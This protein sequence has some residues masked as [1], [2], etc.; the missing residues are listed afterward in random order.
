VVLGVV[1]PG[2]GEFGFEAGGVAPGVVL[3]GAVLFPGLLGVVSGVVVLGVV[4][5]VGVVVVFG[6][7]PGVV[8]PGF[9]LV[10]A[11]VG[12]TVLDGGETVPGVAWF[13]VA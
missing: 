6:V 5:G 13:G 9:W 10:G 4:C 11:G 2:V 12:A 8:A 7:A 3:L 1:V